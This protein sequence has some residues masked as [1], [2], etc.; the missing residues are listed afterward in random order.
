M[1]RKQSRGR[2]FFSIETGDRNSWKRYLHF[3]QGRANL[4]RA[5]IFPTRADYQGSGNS[6]PSQNLTDPLLDPSKS[7]DFRPA[8]IRA[9]RDSAKAGEPSRRSG[10]R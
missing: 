1:E 2:P 10:F 4:C 9:G 7:I 6:L 3:E 8:Q 5:G